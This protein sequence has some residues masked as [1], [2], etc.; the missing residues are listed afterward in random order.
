MHEERFREAS[1]LQW[2]AM[3]LIA[4]SVNFGQLAR[5]SL[6]ILWQCLENVLSTTETGHSERREEEKDVK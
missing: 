4:W 6:S 5:F 3:D 1:S 2:W